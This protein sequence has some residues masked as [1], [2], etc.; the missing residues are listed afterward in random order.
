MRKQP[1]PH[2]VEFNGGRAC[3][4]GEFHREKPGPCTTKGCGH[5]I[6]AHGSLDDARDELGACRGECECKRYRP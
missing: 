6:N 1:M 3:W 2:A 5:H 4:C